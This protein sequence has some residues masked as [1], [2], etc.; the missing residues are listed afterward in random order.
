MKIFA[1]SSQTHFG[2]YMHIVEVS[3]NVYMGDWHAAV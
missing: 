2:K 3:G 1:V